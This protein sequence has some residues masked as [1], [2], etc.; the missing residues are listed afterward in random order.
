MTQKEIRK[1]DYPLQLLTSKPVESSSVHAQRADHHSVRRRAVGN[2]MNE[3]KNG[4]PAKERTEW[5]ERRAV[6]QVCKDI[7]RRRKQEMVMGVWGSE[8]NENGGVCEGVGATGLG[9][10]EGEG[11]VWFCWI[12]KVKVTYRSIILS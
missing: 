11:S 12:R 6:A 3:V 1:E 7:R 8:K 9:V 5:G 4:R 10:K 2:N